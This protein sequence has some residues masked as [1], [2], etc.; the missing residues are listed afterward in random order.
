MYLCTNLKET[1]NISP[2]ITQ[3]FGFLPFLLNFLPKITDFPLCVFGEIDTIH[4][5]PFFISSTGAA[6]RKLKNTK[7]NNYTNNLNNNKHYC[8]YFINFWKI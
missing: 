6:T 7:D 5:L 1:Q 8:I 2:G 3:G 4:L